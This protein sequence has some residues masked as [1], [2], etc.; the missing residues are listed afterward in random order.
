MTRKFLWI[1]SILFVPQVMISQTHTNASIEN[2]VYVNYNTYSSGSTGD[3]RGN[4]ILFGDGSNGGG[5][6]QRVW[7]FL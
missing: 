5:S 6:L 3:G 1:L 4:L 7:R 2:D